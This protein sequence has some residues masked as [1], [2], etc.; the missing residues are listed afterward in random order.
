MKVRKPQTPLRED[1][2]TLIEVLV[3]VVMVGVISSIAAPGWL[4]FL[5]RQKVN[6]VRN[7]LK[8]IVL[9]AQLKSQ[10]KSTSYSVV[11]STTA[12]GPSAA[13]STAGSLYPASLLGSKTKGITVST[14]ISSTATAPT[15]ALTFNYKGE[16]GADLLP[17]VIKVS[18]SSTSNIQ[19]CL[20][21][22]SLLGNITEA[23]NAVCNNPAAIQP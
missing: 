11:L 22:T 15:Q 7:E 12:N 5:N 13:L 17:F 4:A 9:D 19:Q 18:D 16:V 14:F 2:F 20:I 23:S 8:G 3:V 6:T 1:G 10:Q 21:I